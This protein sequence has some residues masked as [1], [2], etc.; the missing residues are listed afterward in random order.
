MKQHH[1]IQPISVYVICC[2]FLLLQSL[3]WFCNSSGDKDDLVIKYDCL[4]RRANFSPFGEN[5]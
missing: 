2:I 3:P 1:L 5:T 4:L